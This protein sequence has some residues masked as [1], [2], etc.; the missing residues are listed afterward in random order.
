[1]IRLIAAMDTHRGIAVDTG[2]PWNLPGDQAF[3]RDRT[4]SGII[5][6]G[7]GTYLEFRAPLHDR[8]NYVLT[9]KREAL[10][11]GF[12]PIPNLAELRSRHPDD[13]I[14]VIGGAFVYSD[15][16]GKADEL[17]ITQVLGDFRCSKFFPPYEDRF[18]LADQ[19]DER[20][21]GEVS[22]RFET[23]SRTEQRT[24]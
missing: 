19:G 1:M 10:R 3:F 9:K 7:R 4:T 6:M 8:V 13:D 12:Q 21:D 11:D 14:W 24:S 2:I 22:Y 17:L 5:V 16:I 23:W 15:T 20:S 18:A